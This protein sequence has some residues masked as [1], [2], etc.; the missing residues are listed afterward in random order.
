[1]FF[2]KLII[3]IL[4]L[5]FFL[6]VL[7]VF[8]TIELNICN[9]KIDTRKVEKINGNNTINVSLRLFGKLKWLSIKINSKKIKESKKFNKIKYKLVKNILDN[10]QKMMN[11]NKLKTIKMLKIKLNYLNLDLSFDTEDVNF[12]SYLTALLGGIIGILIG[13]IGEQYKKEK[14]KYIIVP[15]YNNSKF[16]RINLNCIFS[17]KMV[18]I[19]N[20]IFMFLNKRSDK[21]YARTSNRG[22]YGYSNE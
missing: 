18:H 14:Y 7:I 6:L 5:M 12:T 13:N 4:I 9:L 11:V 3:F 16:I 2:L 8:S 15:A 21:K 10:K 20:V 1:M 22:S 19:I 17:I